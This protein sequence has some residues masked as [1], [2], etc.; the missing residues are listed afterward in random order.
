MQYHQS[1]Y[2]NQQPEEPEPTATNTSD[3]TPCESEL[4]R[5]QEQI[6]HLQSENSALD[7]EVRSLQAIAKQTPKHDLEQQLALE[8]R[9]TK[10]ARE[11]LAMACQASINL[12]KETTSAGSAP[13]AYKGEPSK[14]LLKESLL[15]YPRGT[16]EKLWRLRAKKDEKDE[17]DG[18]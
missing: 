17:E 5:L 1:L 9:I 2:A 16:K 10:M 6:H 15:S 11:N 3:H 14:A 12:L 8:V 18:M 7:D 4:R 13:T